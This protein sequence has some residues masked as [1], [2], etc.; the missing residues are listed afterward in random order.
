LLENAIYGG[1]VDNEYDARVLRTY[2][3]Q[4][5]SN[6]VIGKSSQR[7]V[8]RNISL[9][10]STRWEEYNDIVQQLPDMD[11]PSFFQ[12]PQNI[13][14]TLQTT[15]SNRVINQ[16]KVLNVQLTE[17]S[18]F[19]REKW[20]TEL[21]PLIGVW[22]KLIG[23]NQAT[24]EYKL[25]G[26][27]DAAPLDAFVLM[28]CEKAHN[29]VKYVNTEIMSLTKVI[30]GSLL[31]SPKIATLGNSLLRSQV[32]DRWSDQWEGPEDPYNWLSGLVTRAVA[33]E[34]WAERVDQGNLLSNPVDLGEL[35]RP[36]TF[37]NALRQQTAR[38][39]KCAVDAL[40]LISSPD[41]RNLVNC[42]VPV[43]LNGLLLQGSAF[44][45]GKITEVQ[46]DSPAYTA[47][48]SI[49]LGWVPNNEPD[50]FLPQNCVPTPIYYSSSRERF[51]AELSLPC[52]GE[53][54]KWILS[55][56][57]LFLNE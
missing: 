1:R 17:G 3:Q 47:L 39:A 15:N 42:K 36:E 37:L 30:N 4:Y 55:G 12:L 27:A 46:Q 29:L 20:S 32:P 18:R 14:R 11:N 40:K 8:A 41:P 25:K 16:L 44:E 53:R 49:T 5:F 7:K 34:K 33:L 38:L 48:G 19:N 43:T 23:A 26:S 10:N 45:S 2:L 56:I 31:L 22:N 24:L 52:L 6:E 51:I 9:P 54:S 28:E 21:S 57:A 35:I 50:I 13:E